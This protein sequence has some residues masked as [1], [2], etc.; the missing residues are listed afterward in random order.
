MIDSIRAMT[1]YLDRNP[2]LNGVVDDYSLIDVKSAIADYL[3]KQKKEGKGCGDSPTIGVQS[4]HNQGLITDNG[5]QS[6]DNQNNINEDELVNTRRA[7]GE[8]LSKQLSGDKVEE[9]EESMASAIAN[10]SIRPDYK[11]NLIDRASGEIMTA[12]AER[13]YANAK[14]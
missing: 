6:T 9:I 13:G 7:I 12:K 14:D 3:D 2:G 1:E 8:W 11:G 5:P 10:F 4:N